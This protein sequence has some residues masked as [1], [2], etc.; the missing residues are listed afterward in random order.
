MKL[1]ARYY[2]EHNLAKTYI[3]KDR[4]CE[5]IVAYFSVKVCSMI[6]GD[7]NK[8]IEYPML[9]IVNLAV[10]DTYKE[11]HPEQRNLGRIVYSDYIYPIAAQIRKNASVW[12][13]CLYALDEKPLLK[14]YEEKLGFGRLPEDYEK[15]IHQNDKPSYDECCVFMY[16]KI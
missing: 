6:I 8:R 7:S 15:A 1:Y 13:I 9:Q 4:E 5:E 3:L 10:N 14:Y 2:E 11:N 12:G 16:Q